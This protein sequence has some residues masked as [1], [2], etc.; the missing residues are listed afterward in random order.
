MVYKVLSQNHLLWHNVP[1]HHPQFINKKSRH[2]VVKWL[3]HEAD[4]FRHKDGPELSLLCMSDLK[5]RK[6]MLTGESALNFMSDRP[7]ASLIVSFVVISFWKSTTNPFSV[8]IF[9][10]KIFPVWIPSLF[11]KQPTQRY[12]LK[13]TLHVPPARHH[14][15]PRG[16]ASFSF[17][18]NSFRTS[19]TGGSKEGGSYLCDMGSPGPF[20]RMV[21][22]QLEWRVPQRGWII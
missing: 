19:I 17:N 3:T 1:P 6:H 12:P 10:L 8:D 13:C 7:R 9:M 22:S 5:G 18:W 21:M 14:S 16:C 4:S 11:Y 20:V 15:L 2:K